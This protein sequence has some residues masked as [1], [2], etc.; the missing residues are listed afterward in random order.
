[1]E[2]EATTVDAASARG[3]AFAKVTASAAVKATAAKPRSYK[4]AKGDTLSSIARAHKVEVSDLRA[5][6]HLKGNEL[7]AGQVLRLGER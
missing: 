4:V 1:V 7:K 6:N 2:G 5:W 3:P